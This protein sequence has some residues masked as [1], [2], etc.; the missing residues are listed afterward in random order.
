[1]VTEEGVKTNRALLVEPTGAISWYVKQHLV[2]GHEADMTPGKRP[3][4]YDAPLRAPAWRFA[5]TCTFR[6]SAALTRER[7]RG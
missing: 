7:V 5:K 1:V 2:P 3:L 6:R 4:V